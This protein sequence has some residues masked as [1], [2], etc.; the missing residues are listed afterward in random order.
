VAQAEMSRALFVIGQFAVACGAVPQLVGE[1]MVPGLPEPVTV[2]QSGKMR[3]PPGSGT[4][5]T[6]LKVHMESPDG[7]LC[8]AN[9]D[10]V[11]DARSRVTCGNCIRKLEGTRF[12]RPVSVETS[13]P[14]K[15]PR[16]PRSHNAPDK[17]GRRTCRTCHKPKFLEDF[18]RD[19]KDWA[20][21]KTVCRECDNSRRRAQT[22]ARQQAAQAQQA[23][24]QLEVSA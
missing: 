24:G 17:L 16:G 12:D 21:R 11:T 13:Q 14:V 5:H 20:G 4:G 18:A 1:G 22:A 15:P 6:A 3:K 9:S 7:A 23:L 10:R 2:V 19:A 8:A